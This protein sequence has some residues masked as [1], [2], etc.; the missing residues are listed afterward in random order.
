MLASMSPAE[1]GGSGPNCIHQ[2]NTRQQRGG[3]S[4]AIWASAAWTVAAMIGR[5][6]SRAGVSADR[7]R[8]EGPM[9]SF[10]ERLLD[11][12]TF[13]PHGIC[14]LWEPELIWLHVISDAI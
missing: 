9:W 5:S 13:S 3:R 4:R 8:P 6:D 12:S 14:L 2:G 7:S 11:S 10:L 1:K